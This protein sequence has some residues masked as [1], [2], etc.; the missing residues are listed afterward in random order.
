MRLGGGARRLVRPGSSAA[1][2]IPAAIASSSCGSTST[3]A[4]AGTNSGGPPT[5]VATT[6][7]AQAIA[8][9]VAS[10]NGSTRL[11]WHTTSA[12]ASHRGTASWATGPATWTP[13][14]PTSPARSG[15]S[16]TNASDPSPWRAKASARRVTFFRSLSVPTQR[17]AVP[18]GSQPTSARA[19]SAV[20]RREPV[21]ID[22]AVDHGRLARAPGHCSLEAQPQ[23]VGDRDDRRRTPHGET[24]RAAH[25]A[26]AL[27]VRDVLAVGGQDG[28][29]PSRDRAEQPRRNEEVRVDDIRPEAPS[30]PYDVA[31]EGR[32]A[33][34]GRPC[35][36][37]PPARGRAR[38]PRAPPRGR[39][40]RS[41]A[42]APTAPGTSGRRAGCAR[43]RDQPRVTCR[44]PRHISSA[45]PSPHST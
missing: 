30:G 4:P 44:T 9:S 17:N 28:G 45:V 25:H 38:A 3:P 27:C 20:P 16:P 22:A 32:G 36:R 37:R 19:A 24:G 12:A 26:R 43:V 18:S 1:A 7:R 5:R 42:S 21:E 10:P 2:D 29:C 35:G 13:C 40:R 33:A 8:S 15:P 41:P 31:G 11:G 23:P 39:P 6:E 14:R 34:R